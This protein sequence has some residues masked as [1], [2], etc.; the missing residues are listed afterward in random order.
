MLL[1]SKFYLKGVVGLFIGLTSLILSVDYSNKRGAIINYYLSKSTEL[2]DSVIL[3]AEEKAYERYP[4]AQLTAL[5]TL[6]A[7][8]TG[9]FLASIFDDIYKSRKQDTN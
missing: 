9:G 4:S 5:I 3:A 7:L 2:T 1:Y 8:G 6:G